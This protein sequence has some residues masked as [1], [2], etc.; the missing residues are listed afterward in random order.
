MA[1]GIN[2]RELSEWKK[3][4]SRG[5]ISFITHYWIDD[6]FPNS[7]TVTKVGCINVEKLIQWGN[8]YG[9]KKEWIHN[10]K[11]YPHFDLLGDR[12]QEILQREGLTEQ[13]DRFKLND[14]Y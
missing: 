10:R 3:S 7:N 8:K 6:R 12:Q 2:R 13:L 9:L 1:F 11:N 14:Y 5:E 4:V